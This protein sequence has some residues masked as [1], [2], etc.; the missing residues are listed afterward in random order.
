MKSIIQIIILFGLLCFNTKISNGL[1]Q[2]SLPNTSDEK[3]PLVIFLNEFG[4]KQNYFFT[5]EEGCC[6]PGEAVNQIE[7]LQVSKALIKEKL[8]EALV[9][10][11]KLS[12]NL[13]FVT[14]KHNPRIIHVREVSLNNKKG[15][16]LDAMIPKIN[17]KGTAG[18]LVVKLRK[19]GA[20]LNL[21]SWGD[22][23][24]MRLLDQNTKVEV[25]AEMIQAR[26]AL[27]RFTE[28][29]NH[30]RILWIARTRYNTKEDTYLFFYR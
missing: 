28:L 25:V 10:L 12:A 3:L 20:A 22:I 24:E 15:Y 8:P 19:S 23:H 13:T 4:K 11:R 9:H 18:D 2:I 7:S 1:T 29:E 14:N 30:G 5:L 6:K 21:Q 27:C 26:D 16:G 17:F